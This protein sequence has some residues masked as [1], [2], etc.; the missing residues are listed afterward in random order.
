[1]KKIINV[2]RTILILGMLCINIP[3]YAELIV[4]KQTQE[5]FAPLEEYNDDIDNGIMQKILMAS[6]WPMNIAST[7]RRVNKEEVLKANNARIEEIV[8]EKAITALEEHDG[9][10]VATLRVVFFPTCLYELFVIYDAYTSQ[11]LNKPLDEPANSLQ[12]AIQTVHQDQ[13]GLWTWTRAGDISIAGILSS[14]VNP[15]E[16]RTKINERYMAVNT[17]FI[18]GKSKTA[19]MYLNYKIADWLLAEY[20]DFKKSIS[21]AALSDAIRANIEEIKA[22]LISRLIRLYKPALRYD[23]PRFSKAGDYGAK[24]LENLKKEESNKLISNYI[25]LEYEARELNKGILVRGTT[26]KEF[27]QLG[28]ETN[29]KMIAG[30]TVPQKEVVLSEYNWETNSQERTFKSLEQAYK[31]K[32]THAY[33]ISFGSFLFAG[34]IQDR[35]A[36]AYTFLSGQRVAGEDIETAFNHLGY[37]LLIDKKDY[38]EHQNSQL[39]FIPPLSPLASLFLSGEYFHPR[40]KAAIAVKPKGRV[41]AKGLEGS[42]EDPTGVIIITRDPLKHGALFSQFLADNG[43]IIQA[44]DPSRLTQEEKDFAENVLK[45]QKDAAGYYKGI[46]YIAPKVDKLITKTRERLED[47][48]AQETK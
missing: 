44:G 9:A 38:V 45:T 37:A 10:D 23:N 11:P 3:V 15:Q 28:D 19:F 21:S 35:T 48:S 17:L 12:A 33:S 26:F 5:G 43:R 42:I 24:L 36:C 4:M 2:V 22:K 29:K 40:S 41:S 30:S 46:Q 39:F 18:S 20:P 16:V 47:K 34:A 8:A 31:A 14:S 27:E 1:M 7:Q 13:E 25:A 32:E 6:Q